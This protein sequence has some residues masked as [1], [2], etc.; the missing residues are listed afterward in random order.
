MKQVFNSTEGGARIKGTIP[1]P[2]CDFINEHCKE[3]IDKSNLIPLLELADDG[4][5]LIEKVIP[6]LQ[7]DI[8]NLDIIIKSSRI[9]M[10]VNHGMKK[11][12]GRK[13]YEGLMKRKIERI[14]ELCLKDARKIHLN[15]LEINFAFYD[16]LISSIKDPKLL[17]IIK[18]SKRNYKFSEKAHIA[19]IKNPLVN[20]AIYGASRQIQGRALKV[21]ETLVNF[22]KD[23]KIAFTRM[24]RNSLILK[25]AKKAAGSLKKSYTETLDLLKKYD[26]TKDDK[27]LRPVEPEKINLDDAEDYFAAGNWA[28]PLLDTEKILTSLTAPSIN[29]KIEAELEME[30]DK[31]KGWLISS[32]VDLHEAIKIHNKALEMKREAIQKAKQYEEENADRENKLIQYN[33]LIEQSKEAGKKEDF[34]KALDALEKASELLPDETEARWGLA[35]CLHHLGRFEDAIEKYE[36]LVADF[37]GNHKFQFE[38]GQVFLLSGKMQEGLKEI[39]K[40]MEK[41]DEFDSFLARIGEIYSHM[42]MWN[43]AVIAYE[44]YLEKFPYDFKAWT[45]LGD[46]LSATNKDS[47]AME[48]YTK[49]LAINPK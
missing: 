8:D 28:H 14:F 2:L 23:R 46:C 27:L 43:E 40:A 30:D 10:A 22:L 35:T 32:K 4:N 3:S 38:L 49:A 26:K 1:L 19:S 7:D 17:H 16:N 47:E 25:T 5:E 9:A 31:S 13:S 41:T 24:E 45:A 20:V 18:L 42:Q 36:K 37:P 48:A 39:S 44:N 21:D 11:L 12:M 15:V 33:D 6:L 29:F 34:D